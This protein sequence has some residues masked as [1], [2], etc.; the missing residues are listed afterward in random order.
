MITNKKITIYHF[1]EEKDGY[2]P[3]WQGK[4]HVYLKRQI[5]SSK[6]GIEPSNTATIRIPIKAEL[7]IENGDYVYVGKGHREFEKEKCLA[8]TGVSDNR[9]GGLPHWRV[10]C[11]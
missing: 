10:D 1:D 8:V 7:K 2:A 4:A 6:S 3:V 11:E 5:A 9:R